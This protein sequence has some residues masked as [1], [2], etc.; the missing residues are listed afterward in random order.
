MESIIYVDEKY[1]KVIGCYVQLNN[2]LKLERTINLE[3]LLRTVKI[4]VILKVKRW[5]RRS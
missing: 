4:K 2:S 5:R 1:I 3:V